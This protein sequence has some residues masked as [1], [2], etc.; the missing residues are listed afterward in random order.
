MFDLNVSGEI[1]GHLFFFIA[2]IFNTIFFLAGVP[3]N[4]TELE[5]QSS[6]PKG[7]KIFTQFVLI[8]L[9]TIYLAILLTYEGKVILEW[10]LPEGIVSSLVLG[11][12]VYGILSI[13]LVYPIRHDE[14]NKWIKFF[15]QAFLCFAHPPDP[16]ACCCHLD[17][18]PRVWNYGVAVHHYH[19][20][21]L[22][23]G[24]HRLLSHR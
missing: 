23:D 8:P 2:G 12:A 24:H 21:S 1:Y 4:W 9:A 10:S 7:L 19:I 14:G 20:K 15:L 5:E 16:P 17:T 22:A 3:A 13:L 18:H 6:Y 11:Y